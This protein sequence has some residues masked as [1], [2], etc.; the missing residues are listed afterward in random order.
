MS[1]RASKGIYADKSGPAA[2]ETLEK[3]FKN[4]S[5]IRIKIIDTK[6]VPDEVVEIQNAIR[7]WCHQE[8]HAHLIL[9]SGGT[10][11]APRDITPEATKPLLDREAPGLVTAMLMESLVSTPFAMLSRPCAGIRGQTV[12][13]NLPGSVKA[14]I[15]N[16]N[17]ILTALPHA[18]KL[19]QNLPDNHSQL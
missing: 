12:I 13:V 18:V 14:V 7:G 10:G 1:D 11:F 5:K 9:T 3:F 6:I 17:V 16:L 15:E 4:N 19:A 8:S 2:V